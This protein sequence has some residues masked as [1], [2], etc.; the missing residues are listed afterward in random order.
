MPTRSPVTGKAR[1]FVS[2]NGTHYVLR[3]LDPHPDVAAAAWRLTKP[4]GS[5]YDVALT[6][7][8]ATC[9]CPDF[10]WCREHKD[11]R[12]CKHCCGLRAV[13][14]LGGDA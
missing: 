12:G 13:G 6:P 3:W 1:L 4:D 10:V 2:I 11:E 7:A 9:T 8:G 14:L 5:S